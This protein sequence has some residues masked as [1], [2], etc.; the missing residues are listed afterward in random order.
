MAIGNEKAVPPIDA[1]H[2]P[3]EYKLRKV[4]NEMFWK[5]LEEEHP[6]IYETVQWGALVMAIVALAFAISAL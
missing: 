5:R 4:V 3:V 2:I 1:E 6:V